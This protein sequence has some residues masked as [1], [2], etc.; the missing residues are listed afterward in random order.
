M[1]WTCSDGGATMALVG[2]GG[3]A[4]VRQGGV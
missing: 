3:L 2:L 4:V 1:A